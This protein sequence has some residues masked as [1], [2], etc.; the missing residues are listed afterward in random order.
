MNN[1]IKFTSSTLWFLPLYN[2]P[3]WEYD[4]RGFVNAFADDENK[5]YSSSIVLLLFKDTD[6]YGDQQGDLVTLFDEQVLDVYTYPGYLTVVVL[7]VPDEFLEDYEKVINSQYS[8]LSPLYREQVS[9]KVW[10]RMATP[11]ISTIS[12]EKRLQLQI[13]DKDKSV[14]RITGISPGE[15]EVWF[16]WNQQDEIITNQL[17]KSLNGNN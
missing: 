15:N 17:I 4:Q 13:M 11:D 1:K 6:F 3:K 9:E 2:L 12:K 10:A 14:S 16:D 7:K 8:Q 5:M